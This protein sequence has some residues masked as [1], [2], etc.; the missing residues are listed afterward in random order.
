MVIPILSSSKSES[1]VSLGEPGNKFRKKIGNCEVHGWL[2]LKQRKECMKNAKAIIF[3]GGHG[4]CFEV[5]KHRKPSICI[6][7]QPEQMANAKKLDELKCSIY[8]ENKGQLESA[9]EE[10]DA[11]KELYKS[12]VEKLHAYSSRFKGLNRAVVVIENAL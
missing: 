3:S 8:V 12:N 5:I 1:I 9:I 11:K 6:P 4:T 7:T 10:I 2:D